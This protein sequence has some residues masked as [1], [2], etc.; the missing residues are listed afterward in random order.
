[1]ANSSDGK[2]ANPTADASEAFYNAM[3]D[4]QQHQ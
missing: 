1:M 4:S 3:F 2:N